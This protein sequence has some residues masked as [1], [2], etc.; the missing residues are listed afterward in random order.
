MLKSFIDWSSTNQTIDQDKSE[1]VIAVLTLLYQADD[2]VRLAEQ[3]LFDKLL[4]QLPWHQSA[5]S[6]GAY[7]RDMVAKSRTALAQGQVLEFLADFVPALKNDPEV[8]A[9]L[10]QLMMADGDAHPKE[11]EILSLIVQRME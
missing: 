10:R 6:K 2:K 3:D 4:A 9:M 5:I 7:H 11:A 1:A 8:L